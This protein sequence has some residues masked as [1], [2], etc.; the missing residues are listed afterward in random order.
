ME[1]ILGE[2][3]SHIYP[4]IKFVKSGPII[5][6]SVVTYIIGVMENQFWTE[7]ILTF[8]WDAIN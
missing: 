8:T 2:I 3:Q 4:S 6:M 7:A 1:A 5:A